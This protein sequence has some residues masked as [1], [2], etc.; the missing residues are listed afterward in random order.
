MRFFVDCVCDKCDKLGLPCRVRVT[1]DDVEHR[2][3]EGV[4]ET[5]GQLPPFVS[6][7]IANRPISDWFYFRMPA[8]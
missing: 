2:C 7:A 1:V 4:C 6:H 3:I 5:H 8:K